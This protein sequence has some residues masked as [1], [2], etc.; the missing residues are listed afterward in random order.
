[1][2]KGDRVRLH[3]RTDYGI[4]CEGT[5]IS[6]EDGFAAVEWDNEFVGGYPIYELVPVDAEP[7]PKADRYTSI[8]CN[9][10]IFIIA[11]FFVYAVGAGL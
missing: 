5:V 8:A 11:C 6:A 4:H 2:K 1:M 9:V 3:D 7:E 10:A